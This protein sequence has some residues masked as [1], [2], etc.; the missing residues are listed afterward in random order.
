MDSTTS[1]AAMFP[2]VNE[3][4]ITSSAATFPL[5][6][7]D[8]TSSS[9]AMFPL[10]NE[11]Y[12]T[13]SAA[14][15][16]LFNKD[17]TSSSAAIFPLV[18]EDYTT[19]SA[20]TFPL[21]NKDST[22]SSAAMFPLVN[23]DST[24]SSAATFHKD[25]TI[26]STA[27]S[28]LVNLTPDEI[29]SLIFNVNSTLEIPIGDFDDNWW[30]LVTNIWTQWNSWRLANGDSWKVFACRLTKH[31][32]SSKRQKEN[33][34]INKRR[35]TAIRP[36]NICQA[37]IKVTRLVSLGVI[38]IERYSNSPDHTHDLREN[39]RV[40]RSQAVRTLVEKEAVKNYTPP[41]I[42]AAVK[43]YAMLT[44]PWLLRSADFNHSLS[45]VVSLTR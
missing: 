40:K 39:D 38:K 22:S 7:K 26:S 31:R 45:V 23:E 34:P 36:S 3:D 44:C 37:K 5:F 11:D 43:E 41:A 35:K 8:S 16:P 42:T 32:E 9:A 19:S 28:S 27:M 12:T 29:R 17:S 21:F 18:N 13:S 33:I 6:N 30:P 24:T 4:Y 15:F 25:S 14:T 2:L 1:S 10:V 20:A